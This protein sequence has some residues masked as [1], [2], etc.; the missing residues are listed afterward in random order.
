MLV[1]AIAGETSG[2]MLAANV[3]YNL[4]TYCEVDINGIGGSWLKQ[5]GQQQWFDCHDLAVRGYVEALPA[6]RRIFH[7][8]S[9]ILKQLEKN[10]PSLY[11]G[12]DAADFN[13]HIEQYA[14]KLDIPV[15]HFISPSIWA[16]RKERIHKIKKAVNHMLCL[17][18]FEPQ[19][20]HKAG[21]Q[22][23]YVG[24]PLASKIAFEPDTLK[25]REELGINADLTTIALLPGSRNSE[26]KYLGN[27]FLETAQLLDKY[28]NRRIKFIIPIANQNI[29]PAIVKLVNQFK[30]LDITLTDSSSLAL[31][32]CDVALV[33]SGTATLE[34]ALHKKP[35]LIAY[36]VPWLTA[37][38]MKRQG[39]LP[40]VGLPNILAGRF[41]VPEYLQQRANPKSLFKGLVKLLES[42]NKEMIEEFHNMHRI[43]HMDTIGLSAEII[44]SYI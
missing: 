41:I 40:Y 15:V 20:Y 21:V 6:L 34:T 44:A 7:I 35:M 38:I 28:V 4:Q 24:H 39:Y 1:T 29:K 18:P 27:I 37:Q 26:I 9:H 13:L 19:I 36:Q 8:R 42:E 25:A 32:S 31:R 11:L 30:Y 2:D 22:A 5:I 43:L 14:H 10:K 23:S 3:L 17:F 16:W 12:I 33:A